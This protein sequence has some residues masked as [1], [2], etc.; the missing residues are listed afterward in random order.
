M[1]LNNIT[2]IEEI[3][4]KYSKDK[5]KPEERKMTEIY[6]D[7]KKEVDLPKQDKQ[8]DYDNSNEEPF[9]PNDEPNRMNENGE[10][11]DIKVK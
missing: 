1:Q 5:Q 6:N 8:D 2:D 10:G 11:I 7:Y 9:S 4:K 3:K